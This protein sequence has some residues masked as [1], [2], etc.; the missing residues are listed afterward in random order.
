MIWGATR[1]PTEM[2]DTK[3]S[4]PQG[5]PTSPEHHHIRLA[6]QACQRKK[7][8]CDRNFPCGQCGRSGLQCV[9]STRKP[10]ARHV[11]KRAVDSELRSRIS[12]LESL[13]ESLSGDM[14]VSEDTPK[15][16]DSETDSQDP[17]KDTSPAV[18]KYMGSPFWSSL[19]TEVQA[20]REALE[21]EQA[22]EDGELTTPSTSSG[23][24]NSS[25]EYDLII[26]PPG[27]VYVMPGA[28]TEPPPQVSNFLCEAFCNNVD[29]MFKIFHGPTLKAFMIEGKSYLGREY[30]A[31]C[32]KAV[33]AAVWFAATNT[34]SD[35]QCLMYFGQPRAEQVQQFRRM[36]DVSLAQA[37]LMNTTDLATLQAIATYAVSLACLLNTFTSTNII[38]GDGSSNRYKSPSVD[39]SRTGGANSSRNGSAPRNGC[40]VTF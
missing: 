33:K 23:P 14:Q 13:V 40:T 15:S 38:L 26:C 16:E 3:G 34:L 8:K 30:S 6:C 20:L 4:P 17:P 9:P 37:D 27:S 29:R 39:V 22:E 10:R 25:A 35:E 1:V 19:T 7:I 31:P 18:G 12:K 21:D 5:G 2:D 24:G 32:N 36:V 28:L 11:G